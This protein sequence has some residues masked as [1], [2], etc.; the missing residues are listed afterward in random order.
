[1]W[2]SLVGQRWTHRMG[3]SCRCSWSADACLRPWYL[4][5]VDCWTLLAVSQNY[6]TQSLSSFHLGKGHCM[7]VLD[8]INF[9]FASWLRLCWMEVGAGLKDHLMISTDLDS[10]HAKHF[11]H[12]F[13][14]RSQRPFAGSHLH[15]H[16]HWPYEETKSHKSWVKF[17]H[18]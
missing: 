9:G 1:M 17:F 4:A 14:D 13:D 12:I 15:L 2:L 18:C 5:S 3:S 6:N 10:L 11:S 8:S 7:E 16:S